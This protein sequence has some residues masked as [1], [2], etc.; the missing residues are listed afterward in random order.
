LR[1]CPNQTCKYGN[2][3]FVLNER[4]TASGEVCDDGNHASS[5]GCSTDCTSDESCG[6]GVTD[7]GEACDDGNPTGGDGCNA[8]CTSDE[9]GGAAALTPVLVQLP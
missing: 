5:D 1:W 9:T 6:N 2:A 3:F 8:A 4:D 7:P